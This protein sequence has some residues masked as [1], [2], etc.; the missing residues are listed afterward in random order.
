LIESTPLTQQP[1][2]VNELGDAEMVEA[3]RGNCCPVDACKEVCER[4]HQR[5]VQGHGTEDASLIVLS[6]RPAPVAVASS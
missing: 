3:V 6:F 5:A 2:Q 1:P 4:I